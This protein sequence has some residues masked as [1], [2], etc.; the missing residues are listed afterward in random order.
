MPRSYTEDHLV[1][2]RAIALF[3][4]DLGWTH[5]NCYG[6]WI[7]GTSSLGRE[8]KRDVVLAKRLQAALEKLNPSLSP[9]A[10]TGAIDELTRDRSSLSQVE[11]NREIDK[12]LRNGVKV[13]TADRAHGGQQTDVVRVIDWN[14]PDNN[15]FFLASQFWI[16]GDLYTRRL[17]LVGFVNGIPL[18]LVELKKPGV[19]VAE[20]HSKN[21]SDYKDTIPQVFH[22]N[23]FL[24]VSNGVD[25]SSSV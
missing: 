24:L 4:D 25:S 16:A 21:L 1:E 6:E 2:Q 8:A 17:D 23:G 22:F 7:A 12:L 14:T 5:A 9:E 15:D 11:A 19:P 3:R 18:I 13:K 10:V 20:A